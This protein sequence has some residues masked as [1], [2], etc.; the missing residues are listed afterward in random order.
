MVLPL[1][2]G[3]PNG[4]LLTS[5]NLD[6]LLV[7]LLLAAAAGYA[8]ALREVHRVGRK[9]PPGWQVAS[10]YAGL[11]F[12]ALA[13]LGPLDTFNDELF[14]MHMLQ[15][16]ALMQLAAPLLLLGRPLQLLLR[17]VAPKRSGPVVK[18]IIRPRAVRLVLTTLTAPLV[19]TLLFNVNMVIWHVPNFY[20]AALRNDLIHELEHLAFFGTALLFW[21]PIIDPVPRHH[22]TQ[23]VWG[24]VM[25]FVSMVFSIGLG[26]ILTLASNPIYPY[27]VDRPRAWG[28]S[29]MV[30]QQI[31]GL[32]MWVGGGLI[33]LV[34]L[35]AMLISLFGTGDEPAPSPGPSSPIA[36]P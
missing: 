3:S 9:A 32:A 15:H 8:L 11:A 18:A 29:V 7:A 6:P 23:P 27:Y 13:L 17:A 2:H 35:I 33:Y 16:L 10:Y 5:W 19:A 25:V 24:M 34:I 22:R 14:F 4:S 31:A 26:A 20:D 1:L 12:V 36:T 30:D 21:W 28:I